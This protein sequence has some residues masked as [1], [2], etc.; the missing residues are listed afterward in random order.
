MRNEQKA[1]EYAVLMVLKLGKI[2][3]YWIAL[4]SHAFHL[5][6]ATRRSLME[7]VRRVF[8]VPATE[9][10][11]GVVLAVCIFAMSIMSIVLVWQAQVIAK[12]N[13]VIHMF[14]SRFGS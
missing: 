6:R 13:A 10:Q 11:T 8:H 14:E 9:T 4:T 7:W 5:Y 3:G 1:F 12:Q 2:S